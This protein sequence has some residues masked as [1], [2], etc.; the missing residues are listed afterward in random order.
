MFKFIDD[1]LQGK[2]IISHNII[3]L[4]RLVF[5]ALSAYLL[6]QLKL[7]SSDLHDR[8]FDWIEFGLCF[9]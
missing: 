9:Y 1:I 5:G 4:K 7:L 2:I 3:Y 6:K 8:L